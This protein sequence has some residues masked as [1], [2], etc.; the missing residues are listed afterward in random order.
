MA[1]LSFDSTAMVATVLAPDTSISIQDLYNQF[2]RYESLAH[3]MVHTRTILAGGKFDYGTGDI[4]VI[5]VRLLGWKLAFEARPG[6]TWVECQVTGGNLSAVDDLGAATTPIHGTDYV[7]V[8]YAQAT[9]GAII[10]VDEVV[11]IWMRLFGGKLYVDPD[12]AK[13]VISDALDTIYSEASVWSDDGVTA[14]DGTEG[15]AR[16]DDHVKA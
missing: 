10:Q 4:T 3:T 5:S 9:T 11:D 13:E 8:Q 12:T 7:T 1:T 16:R 2:V 15:V 14:Y 6:P